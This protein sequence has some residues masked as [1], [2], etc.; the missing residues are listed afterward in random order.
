MRLILWKTLFKIYFYFSI[1]K[2]RITIN[3]DGS[4]IRNKLIYEKNKT[5]FRRGGVDTF[6]ISVAKY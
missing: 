1:L 4:E 3:G 5:L 2:V 6:L